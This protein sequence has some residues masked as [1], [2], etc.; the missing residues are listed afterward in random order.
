M[1]S[2]RGKFATKE[3]MYGAAVQV[4]ILVDIDAACR[5]DAVQMTRA[6]DGNGARFGRPVSSPNYGCRE[7]KGG[8]DGKWSRA[9][10]SRR[11]ALEA[12]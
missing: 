5:G 4:D 6:V 10:R 1:D 11:Q 7:G 9:A 12:V 3:R 8:P 2:T